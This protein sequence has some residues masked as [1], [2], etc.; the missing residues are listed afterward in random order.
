MN[1]LKKLNRLDQGLMVSARS[2]RRATRKFSEEETLEKKDTFRFA[3]I[4]HR[5]RKRKLFRPFVTDSITEVSHRVETVGYSIIRSFGGRYQLCTTRR[6]TTVILSI[7]NIQFTAID[8]RKLQKT[9]VYIIS[10]DCLTDC[11]V[12]SG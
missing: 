7:L 1:I 9:T 12:H 6:N 11:N 3:I 4:I 10:F 8:D 2:H 5:G